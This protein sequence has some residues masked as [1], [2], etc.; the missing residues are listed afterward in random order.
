MTIETYVRTFDCNTELNNDIQF[1]KMRAVCKDGSSVQMAESGPTNATK[2]INHGGSDEFF[3]TGL[4]ACNSTLKLNSSQDLYYLSDNDRKESLGIF[5][6]ESEN[7]SK[8]NFAN[9]NDEIF[10]QY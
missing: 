2:N 6:F 1:S 4:E 3:N 9:D 10:E 8:E 7:K 5:F